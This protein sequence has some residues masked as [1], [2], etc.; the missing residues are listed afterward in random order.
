MIAREQRINRELA[1]EAERIKAKVVARNYDGGSS[2][3]HFDNNGHLQGQ[4]NRLE[5][6]IQNQQIQRN[7]QQLIQ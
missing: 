1:M 6:Q 3:A 7:L 4:L 2:R 5:N